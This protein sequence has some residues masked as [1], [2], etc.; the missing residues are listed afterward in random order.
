MT[1]SEPA[2][3][4]VTEPPAGVWA[5][6]VRSA[7]A[8]LLVLPISA[9]LGIVIT[10]LL[11]DRFGPAAYAQYGLLVALALL[12][13]FADLG[14]SAGVMTVVAQSPNP[15]TDS[16]LRGVLV[17]TIRLLVGAAVVLIAAAVVITAV[18][19]WP[20]LL[21]SGLL[22]GAGA[23]AAWCLALIGVGV[24]VGLGQRILTGLGRN[25]ISVL[26]LGLQTP[27]V[28]A[29]LLL[30][31]WLGRG[32][33]YLAVAAY[34]AT[35]GLSMVLL[36]I[37]DRAIRPT[38][39]AALV[40]ALRVGRVRGASVFATAWPMLVQMIAYPIAMQTDRVILS[41]VSDLTNLARYNL[42]AQIY[43]PVWAVIGTAGAA[44]WPVFARQRVVGGSHS[45]TRFAAWFA[46]A[47]S[48][49]C[50][51]LSLAAPLLAR[52]ASGG[53]IHLPVLLLVM[54]S[55]LTVLQA[56]MYPFGMYLTDVAGLR[57]QALMMVVMVPL[58]VGLSWWLAIRA[59][60]VG[61]VVGS[62]VGVG[63]CQL[64]GPWWWIRRR[65]SAP[66]RTVTG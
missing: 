3:T 44:L 45:P 21:G 50:V 54:F 31:M 65:Q 9:L 59:G 23:A 41:H 2:S 38:L 48:A 52:V 66:A 57:F 42:A 26:V 40:G 19:G 5:S 43:L 6:V 27:L 28:L 39:R 17:T 51:L 24:P 64:L 47:A 32:G 53:R 56:A 20:G 11:I 4:L 34:G 22:P 25:H 63:V 12:L 16:H 8:R 15:G 33:Q 35:A 1:L 29:T 7:G 37:A 60:A 14:V 30:M 49:G 10:R 13:P 61:P 55:L 18:G 46:A 62:V 58:N 36:L